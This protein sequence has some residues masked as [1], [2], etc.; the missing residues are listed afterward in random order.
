MSFTIEIEQNNKI[1][2]LDVSV[3][4]QHGKFIITFYRKPPFCDAYTHFDSF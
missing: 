2:F 4:R 3:T 1:S